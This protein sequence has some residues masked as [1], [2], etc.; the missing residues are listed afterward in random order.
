MLH[1]AEEATVENRELAIRDACRV[2]D[3]DR[4]EKLF[5]PL[6]SGSIDEAFN[7]LQP[8]MQDDIN[9]HRFVFAYRTRGLADLLGHDYAHTIL[10]Q[11]VRFCCD[12]ERNRIDGKRAESP[13]R[14]LMAFSVA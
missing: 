5:A 9:V 13:I 3:V 1:A 11:C 14:A 7:A 8:V 2:A 6:G 10:R 4:A 12:H